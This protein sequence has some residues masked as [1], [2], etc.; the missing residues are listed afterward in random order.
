MVCKKCK[1]P[2]LNKAGKSKL[3][4]Q[5]F[6]CKKCSARFIIE[7]SQKEVGQE[8]IQHAYIYYCKRDQPPIKEVAEKNGIAHS[9]IYKWMSKDESTNFNDIENPFEKIGRIK[10]VFRELQKRL[11]QHNR[12]LLVKYYKM[13]VSI[14]YRLEKVEETLD[15][16]YKIISFNNVRI[17]E[18]R[19]VLFQLKIHFFKQVND[20]ERLL[21][22]CLGQFPN[23]CSSD[24]K[25]LTI[26]N[27]TELDFFENFL[28]N[29]IDNNYNDS[30]LPIDL[31]CGIAHSAL[32]AWKFKRKYLRNTIP[33]KVHE[34]PL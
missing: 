5:R 3:G 4:S 15:L 7:R 9:V 23:Q 34:K 25:V 31:I 27:M 17:K 19:D 33:Q 13:H 1:Y 11:Q 18:N 12:N 2:I 32:E 29:Q 21:N 30:L 16:Q 8:T 24:S 6:V 20:D 28:D 14:Y 26:K 10:S 22:Y